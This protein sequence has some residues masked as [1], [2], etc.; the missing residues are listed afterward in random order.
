MEIFKEKYIKKQRFLKHNNLNKYQNSRY[1]IKLDSLYIK[2]NQNIIYICTLRNHNHLFIFI[3][4]LISL[5]FQNNFFLKI[6][7]SYITQI[8][9]YY[10]IFFR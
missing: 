10:K 7:I 2:K 8:I 5:I 1:K 4:S 6:F 3:I 9:I